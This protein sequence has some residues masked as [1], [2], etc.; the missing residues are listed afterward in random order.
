MRLLAVT[1]ATFLSATVAAQAPR[2]GV[3]PTGRE[4][5]L[6][7]NGPRMVSSHPS[8]AYPALPGTP[9]GS[10]PAALQFGVAHT[11][12]VAD[13]YEGE[14]RSLREFT[15]TLEKESSRPSNSARESVVSP[16]QVTEG[17]AVK[18]DYVTEDQHLT[19]FKRKPETLA[20]SSATAAKES[21]EES[22]ATADTKL[23]PGGEPPSAMANPPAASAEE[24]SAAAASRAADTAA[25]ALAANKAAARQTKAFASLDD[26]PEASTSLPA[27]AAVGLVGLIVG[28][29][30][31]KKTT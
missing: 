2:A 17:F 14:R 27:V 6:P 18:R 13:E 8:N 23:P 21:T 10:A 24:S 28:L 30:M 4:D 3:S 11:K 20:H 7:M 9:Q 15:A 29:L 5:A 1:F 19:T 25:T 22:A 31:R 26:L 12:V 16:M